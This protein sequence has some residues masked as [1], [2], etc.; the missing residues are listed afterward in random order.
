MFL[1]ARRPRGFDVAVFA[2]VSYLLFCDD[3]ICYYK[4]VANRFWRLFFDFLIFYVFSV[5][6]DPISE[7]AYSGRFGSFVSS[8]L[9]APED[10]DSV[11]ALWFCFL[12][13]ES[14]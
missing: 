9:V 7:N 2:V 11:L 12:N 3:M 14:R 4:D 13:F 10:C 5:L 6:C 1:F 8:F